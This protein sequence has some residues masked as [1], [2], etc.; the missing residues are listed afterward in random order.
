[1]CVRS[2]RGIDITARTADGRTVAVQCKNR[3][4]R[5]IVPS[6]DMQKFGRCRKSRRP[7]RCRAV[8]R[9]LRV[10]PRSSG[11]RRSEWGHHREPQR[12]GGVERRSASQGTAI[13]VHKRGPKPQG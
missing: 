11:D 6:A 10:Q 2:D 13:G 12:V 3:A 4:G 7:G 8:R 1:M 9:H 5:W